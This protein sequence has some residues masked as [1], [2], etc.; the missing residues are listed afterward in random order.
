MEKPD[1]TITGF[2]RVDQAASQVSGEEVTRFWNLLEQAGREQ[3]LLGYVGFV[4]G[5]R[6]P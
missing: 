3:R 4:V 6:K 5:G 1:E 2:D